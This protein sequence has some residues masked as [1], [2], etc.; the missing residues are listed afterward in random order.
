MDNVLVSHKSD[1]WR[2]P[3]N[4]Y[5][6]FIALGY[7]DPCPINPKFDGLKIAWKRKNFVN[8]PYSQLKQWVKKSIEEFK[9]GNNV[10]LLIPARTDTT[11]FEMLF[12]LGC[13]FTFIGGRLRFNEQKDAPFP[14]VF[15]KLTGMENQIRYIKRGSIGLCDVKEIEGVNDGE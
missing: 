9:K 15:V 7:F 14:S 8:P 11:A 6:A 3:S 2:T 1:I 4:I 10:I 5:Y 12:K 13:E